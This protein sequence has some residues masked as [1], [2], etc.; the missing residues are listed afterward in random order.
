[1]GISS[2]STFNKI[3]WYGLFGCFNLL[4]D[5]V[6]T[7][8]FYSD[9]RLIRSPAYIRSFKKFKF[10]LGFTSGVGL[11]IDI[12]EDGNLILGKNIQVNDYVHIGV[13]DLVEI[14]DNTLIAS[15]VFISDHNHGEYGRD[16]V[17]SSN[18]VIK[19]QERVIAVGPIRIGRNVWIGESVCILAGVTIGDGVVVGAGSVVCKNIPPNSI[20]VGVPARVIKFYD[21]KVGSWLP[22]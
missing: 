16:S 6:L 20:V 19:P 18:P 3:K 11:R 8:L 1:M 7:N 9:A 21:E 22:L 15:K 2:M 5:L 4:R 17:L 10:P 14:G 12:F 13:A